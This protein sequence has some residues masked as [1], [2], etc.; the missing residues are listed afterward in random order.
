MRGYVRGIQRGQGMSKEDLAGALRGIASGGVTRMYNNTYN[1]NG[2]GN[3]LDTNTVRD[4]K[5]RL[6]M[7]DAAKLRTTG[8]ST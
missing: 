8:G 5:R 1:I 3:S 4:I 2:A 7:L 6:D